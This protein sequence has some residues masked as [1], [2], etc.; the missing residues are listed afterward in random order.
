MLPTGSSQAGQQV[1]KGTKPTQ[2]MRLLTAGS[3]GTLCFLYRTVVTHNAMQHT[4]TCVPVTSATNGT[5]DGNDD[6]P[7]TTIRLQNQVSSS[8]LQDEAALIYSPII[9]IL[10]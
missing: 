7:P 1:N 2:E 4:V 6:G 9:L 8:C 10:F 5:V 3:V